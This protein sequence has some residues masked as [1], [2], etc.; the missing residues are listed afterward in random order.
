MAYNFAEIRK[1]VEAALDSDALEVFCF[2]NF[3][4]VYDQFTDGQTKGLRVL[5]LLKY[6]K[7]NSQR[8][9]LLLQHL[10]ETNPQVYKEYETGV[11]SGTER[12]K[13]DSQ[14]V[15]LRATRASQI[16]TLLPYLCDR[17]PQEAELRGALRTHEDSPVLRR[18]VIVCLIH[19][20]EYECHDAFIE[21]TFLP[22]TLNKLM[23]L[24]VSLVHLK[25]LSWPS[26]N[27]SRESSLTAFSHIL[28]ESATKIFEEINNSVD[29]IVLHTH[30]ST[31]DWGG[32]GH[33][34]IRAFLSFWNA[35][36]PSPGQLT[37][38]CL[39]LKYKDK[40]IVNL[41]G[42]MKYSKYNKKIEN[43]FTEIGAGGFSEYQNLQGVVLPKLVSIDEGDAEDW[44]RLDDVRRWWNGDG[45]DLRLHIKG[46]Y[47]SHRRWLRWLSRNNGI[48]MQRLATK[49]K[50]LPP[51]H[52]FRR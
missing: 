33:V 2:D 45:E 39:C 3:P 13:G 10:K 49:I 42:R 25:L 16:P 51:G 44:T 11:K 48:P 26:T 37:I 8:V 19:G 24:N 46:I 41:P 5:L 34:F 4:A 52:N 15:K 14:M 35:W 23:K 43:L 9:E 28:K 38:V 7:R 32:D 31:D 17:S 29:P 6:V 1:L 47:Q 21:R 27:G 12:E 30:L 40:A 20:H 22:E 36:Q 50:E 18:R